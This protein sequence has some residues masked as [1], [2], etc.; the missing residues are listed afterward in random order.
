MLALGVGAAV[1]QS[2]RRI[3]WI[4]GQRCNS[5]GV[6]LKPLALRPI[7]AASLF[8]ESEAADHAQRSAGRDALK[9]VG[10]LTFNVKVLCL[11]AES[12]PKC[13]H[14]MRWYRVTRL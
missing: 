11:F 8:L 14:V 10:Y 7:A 9:I 2:S 1:V 4:A 5:N 13:A 6:G 3:G 12:S